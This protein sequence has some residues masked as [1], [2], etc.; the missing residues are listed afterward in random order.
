MSAAKQLNEI[1]MLVNSASQ[2]VPKMYP[3][4]PEGP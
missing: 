2:T 4:I 1:S 3:E